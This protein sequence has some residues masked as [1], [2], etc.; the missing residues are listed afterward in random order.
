M[1][2]P[3]SGASGSPRTRSRST[4]RPRSTRWRRPASRSWRRGRSA[5]SP[6]TRS[7]CR[8]RW[9]SAASGSSPAPAGASCTSRRPGP[10]PRRPSARSPRPTP[11]SARST[12]CTCRRSSA[13]TRRGS[14]PTTAC[15]RRRRGTPTSGVPTRLG[16]IMKED[17]GLQ[18]VLH[19]HGDSHIETPEDIDRVF[20]ATDPDYVGF[21][22]DTGHIVYGG[23]DPMEPVP[24]VPRAHLLRPHQGDGRRARQAGPRRG[25]ALRTRCRQGL[26]GRAA[27]RRAGHAVARRGPRRPGQGGSTSCASRTCTRATRPTRCP[28][29]SRPASTSR[30]SASASAEP[31]S[32][33]R[34]SHTNDRTHRHDRP[35]R[36]G[37]GAHRPH[38][39][40]HRR[41]PGRR[42]LRRRP[43]PRGR[44]GVADRRDG[45]PLV[46]RGSSPPTTSTP[47]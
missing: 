13:T 23:G 10:T 42:R 1:S 18:M 20:Q 14:S 17:Y 26:L 21:C 3:T 16:R 2:V 47:S 40:R 45:I 28:T 6:R 27:G 37:P 43:G 8:R 33:R 36:H 19:P 46:G 41:R 22:L 12:S 9:T 4:G 7:A 5:T 11:P 38:P 35:G 39:H 25:L 24:H 32:R 34:R 30:P 31:C 44:G 29:P 15:C